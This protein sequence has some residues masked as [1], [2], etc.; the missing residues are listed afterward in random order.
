MPFSLSFAEVGQRSDMEIQS[1][2]DDDDSD[3]G[4]EE[5]V[6]VPHFCYAELTASVQREKAAFVAYFSQRQ[7]CSVKNGVPCKFCPN[8]CF[9]S[10]TRCI[11]HLE[12]HHASDHCCPGS[13]QLRILRARWSEVH[14]PQATRS[15]IPGCATSPTA[16]RFLEDS[17]SIM[18]RMLEDSPSFS[19]LRV[20]ITDFD[21]ITIWVLSETGMRVVLR[22]DDE[23][24]GL[25]R[26]NRMVW[27]TK[28]FVSLTFALSLECHAKVRVLRRL[29][30]KHFMAQQ[31][32]VPFLLPCAQT[33][34]EVQKLALQENAAIIPTAHRRL[35]ATGEFRRISLDGTFNFLMG[36]L[37]Q[38]SHGKPR[39]QAESANSVHTVVDAR[40]KSGCTFFAEA[41]F[42]EDPKAIVPKLAVV[43]GLSDQ[44]EMLE[45]DRPFDWDKDF[46][47]E[48]F[49]V[50]KGVGG[51]GMH[52]K[53]D[54]ASAFGGSAKPGVVADVRR[55]QYKWAAGGQSAWLRSPYF[56]SLHMD[57]T[58]LKPAEAK[59]LRRGTFT[60]K[61]VKAF[62]QALDT[63]TPYKSRLE[64]INGIV[65]VIAAH[66]NDM[67]RKTHRKRKIGKKEVSMT[68]EEVLTSA[69]QLKYIEY[70]ANGGRYRVQT[71]ISQKDMC[72]ATTGNEGD[73]FDLKGW[74][75][76]VN[77]KGRERA[78]TVLE[79][80]LISQLG[81]YHAKEYCLLESNSRPSWVFLHMMQKYTQ[82]TMAAGS[83][84]VA[85]LK[86]SQSKTNAGKPVKKQS[87]KTKSVHKY[88]LARADVRK[89]RVQLSEPVLRRKPAQAK[90][91]SLPVR[92]VQKPLW[93]G[94]A[95]D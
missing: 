29:L 36:V 65:A 77:K 33:L 83:S 52:L 42:S 2:T 3:T 53:F 21:D 82:P 61:A 18:R 68:V 27:C 55:I 22:C 35:A 30:L 84:I 11:R 78:Q 70:L 4:D 93:K 7:I 20:S 44:L 34:N 58:P 6:S 88:R 94:E 38:T 40:S 47:F 23:A 89:A 5:C 56:S 50:L 76:F 57:P 79:F 13:K 73:H 74:N 59:W 31:A 24:L 15:L 48:K 32:L 45:V 63:D 12:D 60:E 66:P 62:L 9:H 49:C 92:I 43:K 28:T 1:D 91:R 81:R 75:R 17:A 69:T 87:A 95:S 41:L 64:Y 80:W 37:G 86:R 16:F 85:G 51:D 39:E 25:V 19:Q 72:P 46:V 10:K 26:V 14:A 90:R 67:S 54:T 8:R 71:G